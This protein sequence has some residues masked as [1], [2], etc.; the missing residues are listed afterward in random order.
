MF[1]LRDKWG[2]YLATGFIAFTSGI[3]LY[4]LISDTAR[5]SEIRRRKTADADNEI[6]TAVAPLEKAQQRFGVLRIG[7]R[8]LNPFDELV[9]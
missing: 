1:L 2:G 7:G 4:L 8:F 9:P 3:T 5:R 6:S